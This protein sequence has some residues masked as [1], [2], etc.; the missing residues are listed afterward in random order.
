MQT[1]HLDVRF[2]ASTLA[3]PRIGLIVPKHKQSAVDRNRL[4]RKLREMIRLQLIPAVSRGDALIRAKSDAYAV[5]FAGLREEIESVR[6][7][8]V[9]LDQR[10]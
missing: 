5:S 7:W 1:P 2:A 10:P 6:A 8:L 3:L 4:R 9:A